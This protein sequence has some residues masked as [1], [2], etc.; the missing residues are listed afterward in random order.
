MNR[1]GKIQGRWSAKIPTRSRILG[2]RD[3]DLMELIKI[4][5]L[6]EFARKWGREPGT[7]STEVSL[8]KLLNSD[9]SKLLLSGR[10]NAVRRLINM[11]LG[12]RVQHNLLYFS[13]NIFL[14]LI[15]FPKY[16]SRILNTTYL[17]T[18]FYFQHQ[19]LE[20]QEDI[21]TVV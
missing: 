8:E 1:T 19:K 15:Y 10:Q 13:V 21:M 17:L 14:L 16:L 18:T 7:K 11:F 5:C 3:F 20:T 12:V 2:G 9:L 6:N 4:V